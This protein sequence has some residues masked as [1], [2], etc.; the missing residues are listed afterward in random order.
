MP[1]KPA[2][3][4]SPTARREA[5]QLAKD[6]REERERTSFGTLERLEHQALW[7]IRY[8]GLLEELA[9]LAPKARARRFGSFWKA[10]SELVRSDVLRAAEHAETASERAERYV[11][12]VS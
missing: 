5:A 9:E 10:I 3:K 2:T 1:R 7:E 6:L 4:A 11:S 12:R 8:S